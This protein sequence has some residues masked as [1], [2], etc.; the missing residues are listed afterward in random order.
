M[1]GREDSLSSCNQK[2]DCLDSHPSSMLVPTDR[3]LSCHSGLAITLS[4]TEKLKTR[5]SL[6]KY[7]TFCHTFWLN[8]ALVTSHA[9]ALLRKKR[10]ASELKFASSSTPREIRK[11]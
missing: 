4:T 11:N 1:R 3:R 7:H 8:A 2:A 10:V 6:Y 9:T 5:L